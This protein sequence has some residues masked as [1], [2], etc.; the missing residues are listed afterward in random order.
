[1]YTRQ[2]LAEARKSEARQGAE[3]LGVNEVA[4]L[5]HPDG[6]LEPALELRA[7]IA[8]Y[9]RKWQPEA[10]FTF[11]PSWAGQI[12]PDHRAVGR[13]AIDATMPSKMP[14]YRPEQL[15][16]D[17]SA[18]GKIVRAFLFSPASPSFF[19][20]VT[21]KYGRKVEAAVV[22][23]SQFPEGDKNLDWMRRL[24]SMAAKHA[25]QDGRYMEQFARLDLW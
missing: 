25:G 15:D 10:L 14:L 19:V 9:Y 21:E 4:F 8:S 2:T 7:Q 5:D 22:H 1:M 6:E 3:L 23:R 24:D 16:G 13:A 12:H 18:V 11:D 17:K 20:D